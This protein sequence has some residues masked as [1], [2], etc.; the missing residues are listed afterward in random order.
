MKGCRGG[1]R[2]RRFKRLTSFT[3]SR[4][5]RRGNCLEMNRLDNATCCGKFTEDLRRF[6]KLGSKG[7]CFQIGTATDISSYFGA[8]V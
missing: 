8:V 2:L 4:E 5:L 1:N 6:L 7:G 3:G